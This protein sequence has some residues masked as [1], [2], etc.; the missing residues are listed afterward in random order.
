M[1]AVTPVL[2]QNR[3]QRETRVG[4]GEDEQRNGVNARACE[5][6]T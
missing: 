6:V 5:G 2:T 4:F 1:K 3:A